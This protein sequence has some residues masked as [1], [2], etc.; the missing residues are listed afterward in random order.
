M[1]KFNSITVRITG[2]VFLAI[3]L[4]VFLLIYLANEQMVQSFR[5]YL[6]V[7]HME[8]HPA[9][10]DSGQASMTL[11]MGTMEENFLASVHK[12]LIWVGGGILLVGLAASYL[13]AQSITI[14][15]RRLGDA[16]EQLGEGNY[17][18]TALIE[19]D[20][21]VGH[22]AAIFNRMSQKLEISIKL[23]R[24]L[25]VNIAHELR[26]PLAVLQGHLEGMIDDVI[27]TDKEQLRSLHEETVRLN[28]LI[29]DLRDLSLAEVRELTLVKVPTDINLLINRIVALLAPVAEEKELTLTSQLAVDLPEVMVDSDR[30]HQVIY[31]IVI[32]AIRYTST[33]GNVQVNTAIIEGKN[34][35][36][37][38]ISVQDNGPGI[39][40]EDLPYVFDHFYR[41]EK[42]RDRKSGGT[43]IG[44]AI[45]K[46]LVE[47]HGG[48]ITVESQ[49][50]KGS[51]FHVDLPLE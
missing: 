25:L 41:G 7:Q 4:T 20:N 47:N 42:S 14:P 30:I 2:L 40:S 21:E 36:W 29:K 34:K 23:R 49:I 15:L 8:M 22:L 19:A 43:G 28:R 24:Q 44:L 17:G 50:N 31:N 5:E 10:S 45:T 48:N 9:M 12:S 33:H 26:T 13:L 38:R 3:A 27:A 16:A 51:L 11:V 6:I 46:Q 32:N 37:V 39:S 18:H 1:A 35:R